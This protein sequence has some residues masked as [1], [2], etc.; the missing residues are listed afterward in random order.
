MRIG[1][2]TGGTFT[3]F[4]SIRDGKIEI[5]KE[6]STPQ[7]PEQAILTGLD[8][9]VPSERAEVSEIVHGSTVATNSLLERKGART[10]LVTT[11][12]FEDVLIIGR[13]T[14]PDLYDIFTSR[15]PPLIDDSLRVGVRQR[16]LHDGTNA[17]ELSQTELRSLVSR[18]R[19]AKVESIAVS[20]LFSFQNPSHELQLRDALEKLKVPISLS[21]VILPEYREYERTSTT[22]INAYLAP[23]MS[24]YLGRLEGELSPT[25]LRVMQ[26]N[27]GFVKTETAVA[28]PVRTILSGPAGGVVGAL[29]LAQQAGYSKIITFDMG[30]TSTDVA[31]IDGAIRVSHE[32]EVGGMPIGIPMMDIHTVGAGG[33]S[34]AE[35]DAGGALCVGPESAGAEPGP[36]CY[37]TGTACTVTDA[38]VVLGRL[39][40]RFFLGGSMRLASERIGPALRRMTATGQWKNVESLAAGVIDV[41]NNNM[42]QAI[43]LISIERGHD[44]REFTLVCFGGGGALHAATLAEG[45]GIPRVVVPP[46]PGALSALGL[47]LADARKDYSKTLL[48]TRPST[49]N[50]RKALSGL[51]REGLADLK[52]EGFRRRDIL[53]MDFLDV[54]YAG[55]SYELSIPYNDKWEDEF[56]RTHEKRYG[57]FDPDSLL[58]VVSV[59]STLT[60]KTA[61]PTLP[62]IRRSRR[63]PVPLETAPLWF[64]RG[65][66]KAEVYDRESLT[67]GDVIKGPAIIGEYSSTTFVPPRFQ[68]DVD[69]F[70]NLVLMK[71]GMNR[72]GAMAQRKK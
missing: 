16:T 47:L 55:Q 1:I 4:V 57:H 20:L 7:A 12:G 41:V 52:E 51:H 42:E 61:K 33:G 31:L 40:P 56:H 71:K 43:R 27:G 59:R 22:L 3:D 66:L 36:I 38:N 21:S 67:Y 8:R 17:A 64:G 68:C 2:D 13:Q 69:K 62:S 35:V 48:G 70:G 65:R 18:L 50:I 53:M 5:L 49:S 15:L 72:K 29:S 28:E 39:L 32:S 30:G 37:G 26:S 6:S 60:G 46:Y 63:H 19:R 9:C 54:R 14:R 25:R 45:L 44:V 24:R 34:I 11:A 10:A 23:V 58:E